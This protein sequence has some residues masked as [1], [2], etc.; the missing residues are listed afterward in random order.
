LSL[1]R[2]YEVTESVSNF[3]VIQDARAVE[4]ISR[5]IRQLSVGFGRDI[6]VEVGTLN[7]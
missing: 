2:S 5:R 1:A 3:R 6:S 7:D 4:R